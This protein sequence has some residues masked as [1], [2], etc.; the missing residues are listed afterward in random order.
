MR[1]VGERTRDEMRGGGRAG[2]EE[3]RGKMMTREEKDEGMMRWKR[4]EEEGG[5]RA[6]SK[7]AKKKIKERMRGEGLKKGCGSGGHNRRDVLDQERWRR[8][9]EDTAGEKT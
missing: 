6:L 2:N 4:S 9:G 1:Y 5:K 8:S 7:S 3:K